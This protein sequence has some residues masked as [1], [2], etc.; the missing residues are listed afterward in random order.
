[1]EYGETEKGSWLKNKFRL[2]G[3]LA[4]SVA[5]EESEVCGRIRCALACHNDSECLGFVFRAGLQCVCKKVM[6]NIPLQGENV[7]DIEVWGRL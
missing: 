2:L 5:V 7:T 3:Y 4:H 1:M 6:T